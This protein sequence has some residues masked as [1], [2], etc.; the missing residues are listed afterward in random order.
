MQSFIV[1]ASLVSELTGGQN[2]PPLVFKVTKKHLS[3]LRVKEFS[4]RRY[5]LGLDQEVFLELP[6][7]DIV[8]KPHNFMVCMCVP[9]LTGANPLVRP[10]SFSR[11]L[12]RVRSLSSSPKRE[13]P[14]TN[15]TDPRGMEGRV[16]PGQ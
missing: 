16:H 6:D 5:A 3:P 11:P 13:F 15:C 1:L 12:V 8:N 2:D 10:N 14:P 7:S 9:Q 4:L